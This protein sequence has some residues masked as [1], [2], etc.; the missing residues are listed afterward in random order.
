M[1]ARRST[2]TMVRAHEAAPV[3]RCRRRAPSIRSTSA[4]LPT[5]RSTRAS[6]IPAIVYGPGDLKIAHCRDENVVARRGRARREGARRRRHRLVRRCLAG[7]RRRRRR[8]PRRGD[9]A[10][11][12]SSSDASASTRTTRGVD[13]AALLG[14]ETRVNEILQRAL[15]AA[16]LE[17]HWV[18]EDPGAAEPRRRP[19]GRRRRAVAASS[20]ATSTPC[21]R[22]SRRNW[23]MRSPWSPEIRDGRLY[24]LGST[25]M[26]ASAVSM[27][28]AAQALHDAGVGLRGDLQLHS[29]VGEETGEYHLGTLA[30]VRAG[31]R[32]D[33]AIVTEPSNPPRPLTITPVSA[34][35][36]WLQVVVEGKATHAGNRP[37]AIRPGGPGDAIG[38]NALEKGVKIV[39][40]LQ[41]L[42]RQWGLTKSA[43]VLLARLLQHHA[44]HLPRRS[45]R[46]VPRVLPEPGRAALAALVPAAARTTR[47]SMREIEEYVLAACRLDPWLRRAPAAVRVAAALPGRWRRRGSTRCRR[48][49]RAAWERVTGE[50]VPPPSP[51]YPVNF[52]AAMEG[53][54][55][56]AGGHPLDRLRPGRSAGR[57]REG[58]VRFAR[59]GVRWRR[60]GSPR[61]RW[62]G[63]G[64][65]RASD[66]EEGKWR[67]GS[68]PARRSSSCRTRSSRRSRGLAAAGFRNVEIG[69]VKG[70]L[71]HL[72]PDD[73]TDEAIANCRRLLDE[74][75][76]TCVSMSGHAQLHTDEGQAAA[77]ERAAGRQGARDHGPEHVH[78]R[79]GDAGGGRD[80]QGERPRDRRR[81]AGG[82]H[83][84]LH[85][86]RLEPA[87][88]RRDRP[89]RSSTRSAIRGCSSTTTRATSSTTRAPTRATDIEYALDRLGHFHL[90]DQRGGKGVADFP[91]LGEGD[92]DMPAPAAPAARDGLLRAR[93]AWRSSSRTTS[94]PP[95]RGASRRR[96]AG[97]P[98]GTASGYERSSPRSSMGL[99]ERLDAG[100]VICAEG[101]VFELERRGYL[102][103]GAV[104]PRG[105]ARASGGRRSSST[106]TSSTPGSDVVVALTYYAHREKLRVIG[107]G[108][109]RSSALNREALA[110]AEAGRR[111]RRARSSPATSPTRT[112]IS[113][114]TPTSE[115]A[116]RVDVRGAGRHGPP[117]RAST[118]SSPRRIS[119]AQ[120][121]A[122]SPS[123]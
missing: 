31:F 53:T 16:G 119:W 97:R 42:E 90:K 71:E 96:G 118:S 2:Q 63:A 33:G 82:R 76:L 74:N 24:G 88:D 109:R 59:R 32:A 55:L 91:P 102:Q 70:F 22:S 111:E 7:A 6:G 81:G 8:A 25:D 11:R 106:G 120:R 39:Q 101:Y 45:G 46:A 89:R 69:A 60:R 84:A 43:P 38:V 5:P 49:W 104:R 105:R 17:T 116:V 57:A 107:Q 103:A 93:S 40:A 113:T 12:R 30:C 115:R 66:L 68:R 108:G 121:G 34:G 94:G 87:A 54:W 47:T 64:S 3:R 41:E 35:F 15:R 29:V 44:G 67:T 99:I 13:R 36:C 26:K 95:G 58:R 21:R 10:A 98:T 50:T 28:L 1:G 92:V 73:I 18:A 122:R 23:L 27:W 48:R 9:R 19:H 100:P 114:A 51:P 56:R 75:G 85:R 72:D 123:R 14:G 52:G 20:T 86:D 37:L 4:P 110:L 117:T 112:S 78:R 79:R 62:S 83:P 61:A 77:H 80:V 65:T